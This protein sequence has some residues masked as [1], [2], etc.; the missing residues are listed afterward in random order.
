[1]FSCNARSKSYVCFQSLYLSI[2]QNIDPK[3]TENPATWRAARMHDFGISIFCAQN[4]SQKKHPTG[5][6]SF[7][8]DSTVWWAGVFAVFCE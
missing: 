6:L 2:H 1:M 3:S 5:V 4:H 8:A 7:G